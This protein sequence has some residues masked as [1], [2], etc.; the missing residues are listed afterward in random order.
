MGDLGAL[1]LGPSDSG[2]GGI[3]SLGTAARPGS[4]VPVS[5]VGRGG[6][7]PLGIGESGLSGAACR[8]ASG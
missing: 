2:R 4:G 1:A 6:I 5:V 8:D 7:V 3:V